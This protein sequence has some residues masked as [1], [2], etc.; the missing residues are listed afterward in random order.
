MILI[1]TSNPKLIARWS[2][3]LRGKYASCVVSQKSALT[4]TLSSLK[5]R[6]VL[7]DCGLPRL[8]AARDLPGIQ[9]LSP[10]TKVIVLSNTPTINE[11]I[12]TLKAG[13]KGYCEH[14][15]R[16]TLL[17]KAIRTVLRGEVWAGR[18][19]VSELIGAMVSADKHRKLLPKAKMSLDGLSARKQQVAALVIEGAGNKAIADRL[20][21]SEATVKA[22]ITS[23]FRQFSVSRRLDLARLFEPSQPDRR[24]DSAPPPTEANPKSNR[25]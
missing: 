24:P 1:A 18:R 14:G 17:Q 25:P 13:A 2:R 22:H 16:G 4:K 20:N 15:I 3:A 10:S 5:T 9:R 11:A 19:M 6:V 7:L 8:R 21:I 23:I 12:A